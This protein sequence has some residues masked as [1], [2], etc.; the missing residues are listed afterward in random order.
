[1]DTKTF[2]FNSF[3]EFTHI[4]ISQALYE[5]NTQ[6]LDPT[7]ICVGSDIVLGD[8][9]GPLIGTLLKKRGIKNYIYGTLNFPITA[10]EVLCAK[11]HIKQMHPNNISIAIDAAVGCQEDV[12]LIRVINKGLMPGLG[13]NKNLGKLGDISIIGIVAPKSKK[14]DK[15]FNLTRLNLIYKMA[16]TIT[17]GVVDYINSYNR[18]INGAV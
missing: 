9:L 16:E 1:M 4:G 8:S 17:D 3:N 6:N 10:R 13:V 12:G 5:C 7:I 14:N 2:T 11:K 15:L 18:V